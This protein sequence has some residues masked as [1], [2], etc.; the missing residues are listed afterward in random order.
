MKELKLKNFDVKIKEQDDLTFLDIET[1]QKSALSGV[2]LSPQG[3]P[4][5]IDAG[6]MLDA[7]RTTCQSLITE[8]KDKEGNNVEFSQKWL[9]NL[10]A[11]DGMQIMEAVDEQTKDIVK[12]KI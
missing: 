2:K 5:G 7:K 8:I 6:A 12:K 1:I 11:K 3:V 10:K 4:T 9:D